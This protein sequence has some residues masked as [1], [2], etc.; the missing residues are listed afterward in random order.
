MVPKI[1][2]NIRK[3]ESLGLRQVDLL[4]GVVTEILK[5]SSNSMATTDRCLHTKQ[6]VILKEQVR[7]NK[8]TPKG[9]YGFPAFVITSFKNFET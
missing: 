9:F 3:E 4:T 7:E 5:N 6:E 1:G 2:V 8:A